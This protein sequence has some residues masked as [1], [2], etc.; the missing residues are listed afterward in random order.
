MAA[1]TG[2]FLVQALLESLLLALTIR[3]GAD[4]SQAR[5]IPTLWRDAAWL[6]VV[7]GLA[8][9][10]AT[11]SRAE[12]LSMSSLVQ[13]LLSV[14]LTVVL[15][16]TA[17]LFGA[18]YAASRYA[19]I[20]RAYLIAAIVLP[21]SVAVL[22]K[23]GWRG[24]VISL[25][26]NQIVV[27]AS[28]AA[29]PSVRAFIG[30]TLRKPRSGA[31]VRARLVEYAAVT[32]PRLTLLILSPG[33]LLLASLTL[34]FEQVAAFKVSLSLIAAAASVIPVSQPFLQ[35]LW[36]GSDEERNAH[37]RE[38]LVVLAAIA[39]IGMCI[40]AAFAIYRDELYRLVLGVSLPDFER[41]RTMFLALPLYLTIPVLSAWSI[42]TGRTRLL[43]WAFLST[44]I[45]V[46]AALLLRGIAAAFVMGNV[47]FVGVVA[48]A[49]IRRVSL[50]APSAAPARRS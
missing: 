23:L 41:F 18:A 19:A 47:A 42:A 35:S 46:L 15:A 10:V 34:P 14:A 50:P 25:F 33:L 5:R 30:E 21:G 49:A 29:D 7:G 24:F 1:V 44:S 37:R 32:T 13:L 31:A 27:I 38:F 16:L 26:V 6:A 12:M 43:A 22:Q 48:A 2:P 39:M 17:A 8:M 9:W 28:L 20:T 40:A 36:T 4:R 45:A 11:S 3:W